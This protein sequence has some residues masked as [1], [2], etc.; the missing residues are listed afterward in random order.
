MLK[1]EVLKVMIITLY[2]KLSLRS[3]LRSMYNNHSSHL[4]SDYELGT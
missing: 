4:S 2:E 3:E 1:P